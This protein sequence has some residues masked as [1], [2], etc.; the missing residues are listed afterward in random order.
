MRLPYFFG[1]TVLVTSILISCATARVEEL[2]PGVGGV[3]T[4][5]PPQDP[6]ARSKAKALMADNCGKK[7]AVIVK[8]GYAVV[9]TQASGSEETSPSSSTN[10]FTGK[11][12]NSTHTSSNVTTSQVKEWRLTYKCK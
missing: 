10:L 3:I 1:T 6:E 11:K 8:E 9:G 5:S 7:K 12:V 2:E 4:V